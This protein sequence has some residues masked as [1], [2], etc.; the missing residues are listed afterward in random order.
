VFDVDARTTRVLLPRRDYALT[1]STV[2]NYPNAAWSP[3]GSFILLNGQFGFEQRVARQFLGV[4][5]EAVAQRT[6]Q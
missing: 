4:T 3:D 6:R 2:Y 1:Y 5:P